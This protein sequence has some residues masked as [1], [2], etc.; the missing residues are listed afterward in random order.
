MGEK[1]ARILRYFRLGRDCGSLSAPF[2][3]TFSGSSTLY[4]STIRFSC[5]L[6]YS[7]SGS[8]SRTCL[9]SGFWSGYQPTCSRA[10]AIFGLFL[11]TVSFFRVGIY[12]SFLSTPSFGSKSTTSRTVGTIV[13]FTCSVGY[14]L[15]GSHSRICQ[16]NG[17]WTGS[18]ASCTSEIC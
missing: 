7:L 5:N 4:Q 6:G 15:S 11:T 13:T 3:G 14:R 16:L 12:C 2:Y 9:S 8:S 17:L 10:Y 18:P 1:D